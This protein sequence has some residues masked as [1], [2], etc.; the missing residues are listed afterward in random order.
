MTER[1]QPSKAMQDGWQMMSVIL[2]ENTGAQF[3]ASYISNIENEINNLSNVINNT[4]P[5][6]DFYKMYKNT[7]I[8]QQ[9]GNVAE[10]FQAGTFNVDAA[11]KSSY[12]RGIKLGVNTDGSVDTCVVDVRDLTR[13]EFLHPSEH[14]D[15]IIG[16]S[17]K[18]YQM[19][20]YNNPNKGFDALSDPRYAKDNQ[21]A[22]TTRDGKDFLENDPDGIKHVLTRNNDHRREVADASRH[23]SKTLTDHMEQDDVEARAA[24]NRQYKEMAKA[25]RGEKEYNLENEGVSV[26]NVDVDLLVGQALKAG[27]TAATI[28]FVIQLAPEIVKVIDYLVKNGELDW[29]QISQFGEQA[30]SATTKAFI[31]GS[32]ASGLVFAAKT[33]ILGNALKIVDASVIGALVVVVMDTV[34]NSIKLASGKITARQ[35]GMAFIDSTVITASFLVSAKVGGMIGQIIAPQLPVIGFLIGSLIGCTVGVVYHIGK[36]CLISF[37]KDSGF[38]CFG[39]VDQ[40]Y[41]VPDELLKEMGIETANIERAEIQKANVD[42]LGFQNSI[43]RNQIETVSYKMV[44]RGIL[45]VN[46][47]GFVI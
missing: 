17:Q 37:C 43:E 40:D 16:K 7:P 6:T 4:D 12:L 44:K 41:S 23:A 24:T 3:G 11:T 26:S 45:G 42:V 25:S 36:N 13:D 21:N 31:R 2:G 9:K 27:A 28:T 39:L 47:I 14:Y 33:G 22:L 34:V 18:N 8:D 38:T 10:D 5:T 20:V 15:S 46:R 29:K 19:K 30:F 35:M 1:M 32:I